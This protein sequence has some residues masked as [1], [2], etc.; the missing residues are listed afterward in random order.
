MD[1]INK[2]RHTVA[3]NLRKYRTAKGLTQK[4]LA[5]K[6]NEQ[7]GADFKH[8]TISSWENGTNSIDTTLLKLICDILGIDLNTIYGIKRS[9]TIA[10]HLP[11]GV[12]LTEEEQEDLNDYISFILSRRKD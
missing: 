9:T 6:I 10:A 11:E 1:K 12:E 4:E 7:I 2:V 3:S 5:D 8:N